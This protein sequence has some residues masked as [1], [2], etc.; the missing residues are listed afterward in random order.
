MNRG[1]YAFAGD[2]ATAKA[3]ACAN[4]FE[5]PMTNV[6]KVYRA[7]SRDSLVWVA[8]S[9]APTG[10]KVAGGVRGISAA[11]VRGTAAIGA[12]DDWV[13]YSSG[14]ISGFTVTAKVW[15]SKSPD[16]PPIA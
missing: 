4:R 2:S 14:V 12:V 6:S 10:G 1:L 7:F 9:S 16:R 15:I 3:A 11:S 13:V 8:R 5:A